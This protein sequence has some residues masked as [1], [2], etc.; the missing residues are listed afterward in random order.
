M[1]QFIQSL[2][3]RTFFSTALLTDQTAILAGETALKAA[4]KN[5]TAQTKALLAAVTVDLKTL[6]KTNAPLLKTVKADATALSKV[7][8]S[9]QN[10]IVT[11][12]TKLAKTAVTAG[13][14]LLTSWTSKSVATVAADA[15]A[16]N[17]IIVAPL[18]KLQLDLGG[19]LVTDL[20][21]I[22]ND[23]PSAT[24]LASDIAA[25]DSAYAADTA[26][27]TSA[28]SQLQLDLGS[29]ST[30]LSAIPAVPN[31]LFNY[32]G[33]IKETVGAKKGKSLAFK[34]DV[35]VEAANGS[36]TATYS[37]VNTAGVTV[38]QPA[39]G[40]LSDT[41]AFNGN[42]ADGTLLI[43]T[44]NGKT[45]KGTAQSSTLQGNFAVSHP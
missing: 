41:G 29:L 40:T 23:N 31:I 1:N 21:V 30:D 25:L 11:P 7:T 32:S 2:E 15:T 27:L 6:P 13:T 18:G 37:R 3:Q 28:A 35:T 39:Q 12:S 44:V 17:S 16:L 10:A 22:L 9:D 14:K 5:L 19:P 4:T 24:Q 33:S 26:A 34:F 8:T 20:G 38:S 43:G 45:I 36:W 42:L